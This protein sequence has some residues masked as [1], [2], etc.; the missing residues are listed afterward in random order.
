MNYY[1]DDF[2]TYLIKA[3]NTVSSD[4]SKAISIIKNVLDMFKPKDEE[5]IFLL[6]SACEVGRDSPKKFKSL[7]SS[8]LDKVKHN[9]EDMI[10]DFNNRKKIHGTQSTSKNT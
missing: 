7:I 8:V 9:H 4:Q 10:K 1:I 2:I 5:I 6:N 3:H